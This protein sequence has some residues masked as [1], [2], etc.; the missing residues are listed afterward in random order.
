MR[1]AM[2]ALRKVVES[3]GS[4]P[5]ESSYFEPDWA[6]VYWGDHYPR[7]RAIKAR[8]DPEGLFVTHHDVGSERWSPD[9]FSRVR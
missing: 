4:Y 6:N 2:A 3:S 5:A 8:Y 7:L 9:G 1:L